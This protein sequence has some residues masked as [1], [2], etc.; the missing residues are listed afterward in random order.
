MFFCHFWC[1]LG[2]ILALLWRPFGAIAVSLA[3]WCHPFGCVWL[4]WA[5][6]GVS[7]LVFCGAFGPSGLSVSSLSYFWTNL[8]VV[9][10]V[11]ILFFTLLAEFKWCKVCGSK[12]LVRRSSFFEILNALPVP[13]L[14]QV[15]VFGCLDLQNSAPMQVKFTFSRKYRFLGFHERRFTCMGA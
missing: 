1:L 4:A 11:L 13:M 14:R 6:C 10:L 7:L 8:G 9:F 5:V 15:S 3:C 12:V 2:S